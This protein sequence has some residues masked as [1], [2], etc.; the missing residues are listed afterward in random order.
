MN[1]DRIGQLVTRA[2]D[3]AP[4]PSIGQIIALVRGLPERVI[5]CW[6]TDHHHD[7]DAHTADCTVEYV[8]ELQPRTPAVHA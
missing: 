3:D 1:P 8:E 4:C 6:S 5:V 2:H 7:N